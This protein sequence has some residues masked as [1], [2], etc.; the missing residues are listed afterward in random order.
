MKIRSM[1]ILLVIFKTSDLENLVT[2]VWSSRVPLTQF[3]RTQ[4]ANMGILL[5]E[6][7]VLFIRLC[8]NT[9][10][11]VMTLEKCVFGLGTCKTTFSFS[12]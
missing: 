9:H 6:V 10:P 11:G 8:P 7:V 4:D 1:S 12:V 2:I 3:L 5:T